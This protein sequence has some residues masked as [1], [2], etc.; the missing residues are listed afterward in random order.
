MALWFWLIWW[1]HSAG[2]KLITGSSSV[3][4]RPPLR[5]PPAGVR[6]DLLHDV[7]S[8]SVSWVGNLCNMHSSW[9]SVTYRRLILAVSDV[10]EPSN[11][12][13]G[14]K[15]GCCLVISFCLSSIKTVIII[16]QWYR[17]SKAHFE[18][19]ADILNCS[20]LSRFKSKITTIEITSSFHRG[21]QGQTVSKYVHQV[22]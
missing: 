2:T 12:D 8:V 19:S 1:P 6:D 9:I 13:G 21:L 18:R 15:E 7:L 17:N 14:K 16:I 10:T 20:E 5:W 4:P 11:G 3:C 22:L